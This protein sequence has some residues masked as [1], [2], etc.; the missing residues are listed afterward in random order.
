MGFDAIVGNPPYGAELSSAVRTYLARAY[1]EV[2]DRETSQY[3][4]C[5]AMEKLNP[6]GA[7]GFIVPNTLL[8]NVN[9]KRFRKHL[10]TCWGLRKVTDLTSIQVFAGATVRTCIPFLDKNRG[11]KKSDFVVLSSEHVEELRGSV[12]NKS[13]LADDALWRSAS[14][15]GSF[16]RTFI[17]CVPLSEICDVSQGLIP[18]DKYRGHDKKTI[19]NR[20]WDATHKKDRTYKKE[21]RGG[22]VERYSMVWNG[23]QWISYGPWLAA[24]RKPRFFTEP[25]ILFREIT[26][27]K[28]S[29]LHVAFTDKEYYNNP[30]IIN[31]VL[32]DNRYSLM[33]L[34]GICNSNLIAKWH[35]ENSPKANK[36]YFL[37]YWSKMCAVYR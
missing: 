36:A 27:P 1:P 25:R 29:L 32:K 4:I 3:F 33:Y 7:L 31:C 11:I 19:E 23:E 6:A 8:L 21:L 24:P 12:S 28:T 18:Y 20:I 30:S 16:D 17:S 34:L 26:D 22:D 14:S 10:I 9:A 15:K 35:Y 13:L 2:A 5:S 37:K